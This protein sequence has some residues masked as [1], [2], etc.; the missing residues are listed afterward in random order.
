MLRCCERACETEPTKTTSALNIGLTQRHKLE[1]ISFVSTSKC[2]NIHRILTHLK[3][4]L[5]P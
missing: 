3:L 1:T 5:K 2:F 4:H